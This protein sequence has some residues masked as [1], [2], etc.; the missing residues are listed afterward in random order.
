MNTWTLRLS[1]SLMV[2]AAFWADRLP[3]QEPVL[4]VPAVPYE[5]AHHPYLPPALGVPSR[6]TPAPHAVG[7][8][9]NSHGMNCGVNPFYP[10]CG[11]LHYETRFIFGS[12]CSFFGE[13]CPSNSKC[14]KHQLP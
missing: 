13:S 11:N 6:P 1:M 9:L 4:I 3:A 7:R 5:P 12:C 2:V 14:A 8:L 10:A